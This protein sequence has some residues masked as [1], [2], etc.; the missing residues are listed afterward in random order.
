MTWYGEKPHVQLM[1]AWV[2]KEKDAP[3]HDREN[4]RRQDHILLSLEDGSLPQLP[5]YTKPPG[6]H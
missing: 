2:D 4:N 5:G 3:D 1:N 6:S